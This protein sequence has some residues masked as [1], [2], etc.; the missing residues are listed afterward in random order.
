VSTISAS[1]QSAI[2]KLNSIR[3]ADSINSIQ[4]A[5]PNF[6]DG[7]V[8][9]INKGVRAA[10]LNYGRVNCEILFKENNTILAL[11]KLESVEKV[12][13]ANDTF[14]VS[15]AGGFVKQVKVYPDIILVKTSK[16][17]FVDREKKAAFGGYSSV[18]RSQ[19]VIT[20]PGIDHTNQRVTVDENLSYRL[21]DTFYLLTSSKKLIEAT[22]KALLTVYPHY[23]NEVKNYV[24]H[25]KVDFNNEQ[26][27]NKLLQFAQSF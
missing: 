16:L 10:K 18:A 27:L 9:F 3:D 20:M 6:K 22:P 14:L 7:N 12:T 1:A 25:N 19:S 21:T 11:N 2:F 26:D 5:Y 24:T 23:K 4:Y 17:T 15:P 8:F 13:I